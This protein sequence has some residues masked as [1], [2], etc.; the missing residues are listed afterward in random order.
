MKQDFFL[1]RIVLWSMGIILITLIIFIVT[2]IR[3]QHKLEIQ[4]RELRTTVEESNHTI[5]L[6]NIEIEQR[7][8]EFSSEIKEGRMLYNHIINKG[9]TLLWKKKH[10]QLFNHYYERTHSKI[11]AQL[12]KGRTRVQL[13][14]HNLFSL[15]LKDIGMTDKEVRD[16][17]GISQEAV[18][19]LRFRTKISK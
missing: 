8:D 19:T 16:I 3:K 9:N 17:M 15:I 11:I 14:P 13:S 2:K 12:K 7:M 1:W 6:L 10:Y 4:I 5:D 18:R